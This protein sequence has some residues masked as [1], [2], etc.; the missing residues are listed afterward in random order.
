MYSLT[1]VV[2]ID[3]NLF[4]SAGLA[5]RLNPFSGYHLS[6]AAAYTGCATFTPQNRWYPMSPQ[7]L[8]MRCG[9]CCALFRVSFESRETDN[10]PDGLVPLQLTVKLKGSQSAMRGTE[11]RPIRCDALKGVIGQNVHCSIYDL[12]PTCCRQFLSS[13]EDN[14][15]NSQCN[16][17][18][19]TY[20]LVPISEF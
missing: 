2:R 12:R 14:G 5:I 8:C 9:A 15:V 13:W 17:A 1:L 7:N 20:G 10:F 4:E 19:A 16:R 18:R 3:D 11:K 6:S